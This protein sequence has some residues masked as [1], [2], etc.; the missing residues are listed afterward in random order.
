MLQ[1]LYTSSCKETLD[2]PQAD[3]LLLWGN[4]AGTVLLVL[5]PV[6]HASIGRLLVRVTL[7]HCKQCF[8]L[9]LVG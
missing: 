8:R 1:Y 5:L 2:C 3:L 7:S 6:A 9:L 4:K